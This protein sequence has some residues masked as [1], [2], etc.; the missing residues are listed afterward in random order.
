MIEEQR[1]RFNKIRDLVAKDDLKAAFKNF[2]FAAEKFDVPRDTQRNLILI[3]NELSRLEKEH[4]TYGLPQE[5]YT[6]RRNNSIMSFLYLIEK[7]EDYLVENKQDDLPS[8]RVKKWIPSNEK[9]TFLKVTNISKSYL[10]FTLQPINFQLE[11][12]SILAVIGKNASGKSTL[13]RLLAGE[14]NYEE[15]DIEYFGKS[16]IKD[17]YELKKK[18]G[19]IPQK[20]SPTSIK[21]MDI[22]K[23]QCVTHDIPLSELDYHIQDAI[24]K[25]DLEN[26]IHKNWEN[27]SGGF[28]MR[29]ELAKT[30]IWRPQILIM[31]EPLA[32]LDI[33]TQRLFLQD[34]REYADSAQH[35]IS[36]I[37]TSQHIE[38]I[39]SIADR[40]I[41]LDEGNILFNGILSE[42]SEN[43]VFNYYEIGIPHDQHMQ[44]QSLVEGFHEDI[45][46]VQ[47]FFDLLT[48]KVP[49]HLNITDIL[50]LLSKAGIKFNYF[51]D[52]TFSTRRLFSTRNKVY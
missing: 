39:E 41:F 40:V 3:K 42:L 22:L 46:W 27:L 31:D 34:I 11:S 35:P 25:M 16:D 17:W 44:A 2:A 23:F 43:R 48:L 6:H 29:F 37:I 50:N 8:K 36:V 47:D 51:R 32:N 52:I 9:Q 5:Y 1:I 21:L 30:I 49:I 28:Q 26:E 7:S 33:V 18:I 13:L 12:H 4:Q 24:N 45:I 15:G 10:D 20:I 19:Y 14:E 38:E